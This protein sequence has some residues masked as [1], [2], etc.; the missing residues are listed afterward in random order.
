[1]PFC[2]KC[3]TQNSDTASACVSCGAS[4]GPKQ[5]LFGSGSNG[6]NFFDRIKSYVE[7]LMLFFDSGKFF[8]ISWKCLFYHLLAIVYGLL[9]IALVVAAIK[10]HIFD[11]PGKIIFVFFLAFIFLTLASFLSFLAVRSRTNNFEEAT[12]SFS[13]SKVTLGNFYDFFKVAC[14]HSIETVAYTSGIFT[15]IAVFGLAFCSLFIDKNML[16]GFGNSILFGFIAGPLYAYINIFITKVIVL[17]LNVFLEY[18]PKLF[19]IPIRALYN[20][21]GIIIDTRHSLLK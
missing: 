7:S 2:S 6:D 11:M 8:K 15:S 21:F 13:T 4:L 9:P 10:L 17:F 20:L 18:L 12:K 14:V 16:M 1:M 19:I 5:S 3:G